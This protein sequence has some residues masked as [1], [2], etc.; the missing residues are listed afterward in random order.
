MGWQAGNVVDQ[1][2]S[3]DMYFLWLIID[4]KLI[5]DRPISSVYKN[6]SGYKWPPVYR[7]GYELISFFFST[8]YVSFRSSTFFVFTVSFLRVSQPKR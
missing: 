4:V 3:E 2:M 7:R 6:K 5:L 8:D 1:R